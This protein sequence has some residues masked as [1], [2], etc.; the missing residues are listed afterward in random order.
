MSVAKTLL[1]SSAMQSAAA[2]LLALYI[3]LVY[4][5][6]CKR[7]DVDAA[8]LPYVQGM[9]NAIFAFWH[10]RMMVLPAFCP[11]GRKMRVLISRHRDGILI[12]RVISHF[13]QATVSGSSS[14]GGAAAAKEIRRALETGD[15]IGITPDGP[16]GPAQT[17]AFGA[18]TLARLTG[19]PVL[20]VAFASSRT[21]RL[22]SW[23]RFVLA[24]PFGRIVLCV[25]AP[26]A[27]PDTASGEREELLRRQLEHAMNRLVEKAEGAIHG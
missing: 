14:K 1:K 18:V 15:N 20:P 12:S 13:G 17:A 3:R 25:G 10:G 21:V 27:M 2:W 23:D 9:E 4:L 16:R 11:P 26:I 22:K 6:S 19:K 5:T 7:L 8:A 24:L